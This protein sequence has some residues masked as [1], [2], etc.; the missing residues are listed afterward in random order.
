VRHC[1]SDDR[2]SVHI[3]TLS[4]GGADDPVARHVV[5]LVFSRR[6]R[7]HDRP[8][9]WRASPERLPSSQAHPGATRRTSGNFPATQ[10]PLSRGSLAAQDLR[11]F[12]RARRS[13]PGVARRDRSWLRTLGGSLA[14]WAAEPNG[15]PVSMLPSLLRW[16]AMGRCWWLGNLGASFLRSPSL[17]A[18][19]FH[20]HRLAAQGGIGHRQRHLLTPWARVT[21]HSASQLTD[22][23]AWT[24]TP[25]TRRRPV[26]SLGFFGTDGHVAGELPV[27]CL[28]YRATELKT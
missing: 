19:G 25:S 7:R 22:H 26:S 18:G 27:S 4:P 11:A 16:L 28:A 5:P 10:R 9:E 3:R 6:A 21:I 24:P 17:M 15:P 14:R 13:Q 23:D 2:Y 20:H 1:R 8:P 12:A